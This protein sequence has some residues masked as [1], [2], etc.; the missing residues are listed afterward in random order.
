MSL[1][2]VKDFDAIVDN[3]PFFDQSSKNKQ[4]IYEKLVEYQVTMTV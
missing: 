4:E 2:E 3:K 1:F